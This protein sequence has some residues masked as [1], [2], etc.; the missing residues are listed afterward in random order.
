MQTHPE[1]VLN[2]HGPHPLADPAF[3][4]SVRRAGE[5]SIIDVNGALLGESAAEIFRECIRELLRKGVKRLVINLSEVDTVDSY[6]WGALA[7]AYNWIAS[8]AGQI[9]FFGAT[10]RVKR[11][12]SRLR[13]DS[14]FAMFDSEEDALR[15]F[16]GRDS[17]APIRDSGE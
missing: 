13:L 15:A 14:V 7:A 16:A 17:Q 4:V 3:G 6:G 11:T 9:K 8:A 5:A 2:T 10:P 1:Q 12:L